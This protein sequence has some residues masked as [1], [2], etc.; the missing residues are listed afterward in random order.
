LAKS[1]K[2]I[3]VFYSWRSDKPSKTNRYAI[4]KAID[5][6]A[7][8]INADDPKLK[9]VPDEA[10]R[11]VSGADNIAKNIFEKIARADIFVAD[12]TPITPKGADRSCPNPNV[13]IELGY[14]VAELDWQR[15]ILLFNDAFGEM[16]N[17]LPFDIIQ[18]RVG[19]YAMAEGEVKTAQPK[20]DGLVKTAIK[21]VIDSNPKRPAELSGLTTEEIQHDRD[22]EMITRFMSNI[23]LGVLDDVIE[24][25]PNRITSRAIWFYEGVN[26]VSHSSVFELYDPILKSAVERLV[27]SWGRALSYDEHYREASNNH[28]HVFGNPGDARLKREQQAAWDDIEK[29]QGE[30]AQAKQD[31]LDR[32]REAYLEVD[33]KKTSSKAWKCYL[34]AQKAAEMAWGSGSKSAKQK[35]KKK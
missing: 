10:M 13:L 9:V 17:E 21:A 29:A 8:A 1:P 28:V 25:L 22:V 11:D 19:P 14:A 27:A 16:K 24:D 2:K 33:V 23:A 4:Q 12:I 5:A 6:A 15:V 35:A 31:L 34:A 7:K 20:L 26:G 3:R 30:M 32:L 18:N